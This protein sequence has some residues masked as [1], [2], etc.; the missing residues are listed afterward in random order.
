LR[1]R[2]RAKLGCYLP[3]SR[4]AKCRILNLEFRLRVSSKKRSGAARLRLLRAARF[5]P[6]PGPWA[7]TVRD[8]VT[9]KTVWWD[10]NKAMTPQAFDTL[11]ADM[12]AHAGGM[13]LYARRLVGPH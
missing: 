7:L 2:R 5:P 9:D 1:E 3:S 10:N 13:E 6:K 4:A 8:A 12:L 11:Y